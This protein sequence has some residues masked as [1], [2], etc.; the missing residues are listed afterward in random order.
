MISTRRL[1]KYGIDFESED[2]KGQRPIHKACERGDYKMLK[3]L[4]KA[5]VDLNCLDKAGSCPLSLI[6][7]RKKK[8]IKMLIK[9]GA[10]FTD[11]T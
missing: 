7:G 10:S 9:S 2:E 6:K 1:L 5:G 8:L 4:I 3:L 11:L